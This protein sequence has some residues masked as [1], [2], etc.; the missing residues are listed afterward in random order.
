MGL[1][2]GVRPH[3]QA[4]PR[5]DR[6]G[7][8]IEPYLTYQWFVKTE[9][10]AGP[11]MEAVRDGRV[12]LVPKSWENTYFAWMSEI[13]DWCISRQIWWGHRIPAWYSEAGDVYVARSENEA[14]AKFALPAD[15]PLRQDEDVLDTWFSSALWPFATLGWPKQTP[16]FEAF[17]P[18]TVMVTAFDILFFWVARMIMMGLKLTGDVP[19]RTVFIHGLVRDAHGQKM[20]KSKGNVLDPLDIIEGRDLELLVAKM[21]QG[22]MQPEMAA[23][24][25]EKVRHEFPNGFEASALTRSASPSQ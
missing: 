7:A 6:S 5:G 3:M 14:R 10:L 15:L 18:T 1:L 13:R 22:L 4:I 23:S 25:A 16:E 8:V 21:T 9:S 2:A 17:Y 24:I 20:S 19:F 12:R 11:A